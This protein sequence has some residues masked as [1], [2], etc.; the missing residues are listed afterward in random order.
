MSL[1]VSSGLHQFFS[2]F[3]TQHYLSILFPFIL[4]FFL[5]FSFVNG[6]KNSMC[7]SS[8]TVLVV[9]CYDVIGLIYFFLCSGCLFFL[10][11]RKLVFRWIL[12]LITCSC[13]IRALQQQFGFYCLHN[14]SGCVYFLVC[15]FTNVYIL[16]GFLSRL[17]WGYFV[18]YRL[19][20]WFFWV[21]SLLFGSWLEYLSVLS[22]PVCFHCHG[23]SFY[24]C[25]GC[26]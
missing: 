17:L 23:Y 18:L 26:I 20:S 15:L 19:V 11:S 1:H 10:F 8:N 16:L 12:V 7:S 22:G 21:E 14:A 9:L 2:V 13:V 24:F 5:V 3:T 4:V 6:S 25:F